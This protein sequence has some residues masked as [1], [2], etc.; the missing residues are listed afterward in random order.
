[1]SDNSS[2]PKKTFEDLEWTAELVSKFQSVMAAN[3]KRAKELDWPNGREPEI[4]FSVNPGTIG[5]RNTYMIPE[6]AVAS[7]RIPMI[8]W[9]DGQPLVLGYIE[10]TFVGNLWIGFGAKSAEGW[11]LDLR[12][13]AA[14]VAIDNEPKPVVVTAGSNGHSHHPP[15]L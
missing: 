3:P 9:V 5:N 14:Y 4:P 2:K 12:Q 10:P 13:D 1:M 7:S 15:Q 6:Q 8:K 11:Q